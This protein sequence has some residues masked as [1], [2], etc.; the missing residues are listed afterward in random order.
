MVVQIQLLYR[1]LTGFRESFLRKNAETDDSQVP[2]VC[3]LKQSSRK[4][5]AG[6]VRRKA[7]HECEVNPGFAA[8]FV[9]QA[10]AEG[11]MSWLLD[12]VRIRLGPINFKVPI[13]E[14]VNKMIE[15]TARRSIVVRLLQRLLSLFP[16][17]WQV[18]ASF[19]HRPL[20]I[21]VMRRHFLKQL[22]EIFEPARLIK[23]GGLAEC[24][25]RND[26]SSENKRV[27]ADLHSG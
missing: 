19:V 18:H 4:K 10:L 24:S 27:S 21:G 22:L 25:R 23:S 7:G 13:A 3:Q 15:D 1:L 9:T 12:F 5:F 11:R 17:L 14:G 6:I 20:E 2:A 8:C 16:Q 26:Q